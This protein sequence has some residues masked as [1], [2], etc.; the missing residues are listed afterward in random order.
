MTKENLQ[1]LAMNVASMY[2]MD[3]ALVC[4]MCEHES[5]WNPEAERY[6]PAFFD[7]YI[8]T[9][10]GLDPE[11][12]RLRAT[13]IGLMQVMGQTAREQGF[14]APLTDLRQAQNSLAHGCKKLAK[15]LQKHSGVVESALLAYNGGSDKRYPV[16]VLKLYDKYT[17]RTA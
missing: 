9:M 4:A 7:R 5:S 2:G 15:C 8:S 3:P 6:E 17:G 12:M 14:D 10:K 1:Q 16:M 11:E 13:S